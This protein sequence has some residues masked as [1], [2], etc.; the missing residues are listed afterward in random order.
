MSDHLNFL[1]QYGTNEHRNKLINDENSGVRY[2]VAEH[3]TNEHRNQLIND[4][5]HRVR[6]EANKGRFE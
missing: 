2:A 6:R 5:D 1:A 4:E 3:G